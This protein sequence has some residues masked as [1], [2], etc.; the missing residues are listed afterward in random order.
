MKRHFR[1]GF[2]MIEIIT[3]FAIAAVL[4]AITIPSALG[5][6]ESGRQTRRMHNAR[7]IYLAAQ[8]QLT[9]L[10][11]TKSLKAELAGWPQQFYTLTGGEYTQ[12]DAAIDSNSVYEALGIADVVEA[13]GT[14]DEEAGNHDAVVYISKPKWPSNFYDINDPVIR[15]LD[16]VIQDKT[17]LN[18]AI[19][20]EFNVRTGIVLSVFYGENLD[21]DDYFD[22][23]GD[24][25]VRDISRGTVEYPH[26]LERRQGYYGV[27]NT[28]IAIDPDSAAASISIHDSYETYGKANALPG[29]D[30]G[31]NM[32]YADIRLPSSLG[33]D[34]EFELSI[35]NVSVQTV[36]FAEV[37]TSI[38]MVS[39]ARPTYRID[40]GSDILRIIWVLDYVR[41]NTYN[42][43]D[44]LSISRYDG[45][46]ADGVPVGGNLRAGVR[47]GGLSATSF[48]AAHSYYF[49]QA[50]SAYA[51][52]RFMVGSARH[53]YNIRFY[54]GGHFTQKEDIDL[55]DHGITNFVP[56][57]ISSDPLNDPSDSTS[58][59]FTGTYSGVGY[60]ISNLITNV[61]GQA[62]LFGTVAGAINALTLKNPNVTGTP[63]ITGNGNNTGAV[64]GTLEDGG[65][66]AGAYVK[67]SNDA[68]KITGG[69]TGG[70]AG[71]N[72]GIIS[73]ST[74]VSAS[75]ETHIEGE[76][77]L[78]GIAGVNESGSTVARTLFLALAP[79][80]EGNL[81]PITGEHDAG[82]WLRGGVYY[83][84]GEPI[85]P[86]EPSLGLDVYNPKESNDDDRAQHT[87]ALSMLSPIANWD[88]NNVPPEAVLD[89]DNEVHPYPYFALSSGLLAE[90]PYW[91]VA[92][93]REDDVIDSKEAEFFYYEIYD[94]G[95][96]GYSNSTASGLAP[97]GTKNTP[98]AHDGYGISLQFIPDSV[99]TLT[100]GGEDFEFTT[101]EDGFAAPPIGWLPPQRYDTVLGEDGENY[102]LYRLFIPNGVAENTIIGGG[103]ENVPIT[104]TN[105]KSLHPVLLTG[106][107]NPLFAP[108]DLGLIR[109]PRHFENISHALGG[110]YTQQ[111]DLDFSIYRRELAAGY[112]PD[113][114]TMLAYNSAIIEGEFTGTYNGAYG[115]TR[116][117]VS[118]VMINSNASDIGL[119]AATSGTISN[120]MLINADFTGTLNVGGVA[121]ANSGSILDS[122]VRSSEIKGGINVGGIAG[123]SSGTISF[124]S[125]WHST[126]TGTGSAAGGIAGTNSGTVKDV[127]FLATNNKDDVPVSN[128]GG[129][130]V[131]TNNGWVSYALYI[132]PAPGEGGSIYPIVRSGTAALTT[133]S[134][135]PTCFYL[136]GNTYSLDEGRSWPEAQTDY[137]MGAVTIG[138]GFPT[139][140]FTMDWLENVYEDLKF[141]GKWNQLNQQGRYPYPAF[142]DAPGKWPE[143]S[144]LLNP[145]QV[146]RMD[147][148]ELHSVSDRPDDVNFVNGNFTDPFVG[149]I[150]A[151]AT[152]PTV[153]TPSSS[154]PTD[155]TWDSFDMDL[156]PGWYTRPVQ[157]RY[158]YFNLSNFSGTEAQRNQDGYYYYGPVKWRLIELQEP[159]GKR[160]F[161]PTNYLGQYRARNA[162]N[163]RNSPYRYAELNAQLEGTLFQV[164]PTTPGAEFFYSFYHATNILSYPVNWTNP[165]VAARADSM[166]FYLSPI[167][168]NEPILV[169]NAAQA[170]SRDAAMV[171]IRPCSS[172]RAETTNVS[173]S[174]YVSNTANTG[175]LQT[176]A[177]LNNIN[178]NP[179]AWRTVKYDPRSGDFQGFDLSYHRNRRYIQPGGGTALQNI[180]TAGNVFLYDV[181]V[182]DT[183][184]AAANGGTRG[185]YGISFWST[186]DLTVPA[187]TGGGNATTIPREGITQAQFNG[188]GT[189]AWE[190]LADARTN[191]IGCWNVSY[192]WKHYYGLYTVPAGQNRTEFAFQS[193]TNNPD[194]GN[195]LAG[196]DFKSP[197][198]LSVTKTFDGADLT[199]VKPGDTVPVEMIVGSWG[200]V[201][202]NNIV[203]TDQFSPFNKY[204]DYAG[205]LS[206]TRGGNPVSFIANLP[207]STGSVNAEELR[208]TLDPAFT[209][210]R[211][212]TDIAPIVIKF[213]VRV[214]DYQLDTDPRVSTLY[215]YIRN[216]AAVRFNNY[217]G[218]GSGRFDIPAYERGGPAPLVGQ[219]A[220]SPVRMDINDIS[221]HKT[222]A[223][224]G[225]GVPSPD[226][227]IDDR[228]FRV[229]LII[230]DETT[231]RNVV[232]HGGM[233]TDVIPPGFEIVDRG[234]LPDDTVP[235]E[236][237]D[238]TTRLVIRNANLT[239]N[240]NVISIGYYYT[241]E[242]TGNMYGISHV[243]T[244]ADYKYRYDSGDGLIDASLP[245]PNPV[246]GLRSKPNDIA[247]TGS[248][249]GTVSFFVPE[250]DYI[251]NKRLADANYDVATT[252]RL[253]NAPDAP[254][255]IPANAEGH[256]TFQI[257]GNNVFMDGNVNRI[258]FTASAAGTYTFW[259]QV[260]V[261]A[262]RTGAIPE[263]FVLD[264]VRRTVTVT[265]Q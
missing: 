198:F 193:R 15:L 54:K 72:R 2:T 238:G 161:I 243:S 20:I 149:S 58:Y 88:N 228:R 95:D 209:L 71:V 158:H 87:I 48:N 116:M 82:A 107:Y 80:T 112:T 55:G 221:L 191:V 186:R 167:G 217:G 169:N 153:N 17:I 53:L 157:S 26:A 28:G 142:A 34:F 196:V 175:G 130:I 119:F 115:T 152:S 49:T 239:A 206:V 218:S 38:S 159:N 200:E 242:Y 39:E 35:N 76:G 241:L 18:D 77:K 81:A 25:S 100:I 143:A 44:D 252:I 256:T 226:P 63:D 220:S 162:P 127:Y 114:D 177:N 184:T 194:V 1:K 103:L 123:I 170:A 24:D 199:T 51:S 89:P 124:C 47:A 258:D 147:W 16:P 263:S 99:Y 12:N 46:F 129:G 187:G 213:N 225:E 45:E 94:N 190:W 188:T 166:N 32:L 102:D 122:S 93:P 10:R 52:D 43:G 57:G 145:V 136:Y 83:L 164:L 111:L 40:D 30:G 101:D 29:G 214:R 96:W 163:V 259:Y 132:A 255:P 246:V 181:W 183:T 14:F 13:G 222:V 229:E 113:G 141:D 192:G 265:V 27:D 165:Q 148:D 189:G 5:V 23:L 201:A 139:T 208:I 97:G 62:G 8:S 128:G 204:M 237:P 134:G 70:I 41:G 133:P 68:K 219:N 37:N 79:E 66:L 202:A 155:N 146:D 260:E 7:T 90:N 56:I 65:R 109:S 236:N 211:A 131:V 140:F 36:S 121:G 78:G 144:T 138:E 235:V 160:D 234:N 233:I 61:P 117:T 33:G 67:F 64:C 215:Y 223:S 227:L 151:D 125:V 59:K 137:N 230:R 250:Q 251:A 168:D 85:R 207:V 84:S 118:N 197:A 264:S 150:N 75:S 92:G 4:A 257:G 216:Q 120:I 244:F 212:D 108:P 248:V 6:I 86:D 69:D 21:N 9:E 254:S 3:I 173:G 240:P 205:G 154:A 172:P 110:N 104:L 98:V 224:I 262:T 74:F 245:F 60:E 42:N 178:L 105:E 182:G 232:T 253:Y 231:G 247:R 185:G 31:R 171:L 156:I 106:T 126:V 174:G 50:A 203:I 11:V 180:P 22:Y 73:D 261:R 195:Y 19:L 176:S 135:N 249:G 179:N 210:T 91:P